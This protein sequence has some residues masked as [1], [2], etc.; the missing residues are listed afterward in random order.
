MEEVLKIMKKVD[1]D[2]AISNWDEEKVIEYR[3]KMREARKA[4]RRINKQNKK[5]K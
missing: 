3:R 5:S 1:E 4:Q 2:L